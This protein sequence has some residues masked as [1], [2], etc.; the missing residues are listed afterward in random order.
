MMR[1]YHFS[2]PRCVAG[3]GLILIAS[4][5]AG[6]PRNHGTFVGEHVIFVDVT[7]SYEALSKAAASDVPW[8]MLWARFD[9]VDVNTRL[10]MQEELESRFPR[11]RPG[12]R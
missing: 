11:K 6:A 10:I 8:D 7:E 3:V 2:A 12:E 5:C 4:V 1:S 9:T